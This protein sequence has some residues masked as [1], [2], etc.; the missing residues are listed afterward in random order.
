MKTIT[1]C[2][3]KEILDKEYDA[4]LKMTLRQFMAA[5]RKYFPKE[6]APKE[7]WTRKKPYIFPVLKPR[8]ALH[9]GRT[10]PIKHRVKGT[11]EKPLLYYDFTVRI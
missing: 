3:L 8:E 1:S 7:V 9:G 2:K 11:K 10:E 5:Y 4:E 6:K